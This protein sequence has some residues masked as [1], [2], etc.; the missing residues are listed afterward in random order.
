MADIEKEEE[1]KEEAPDTV[2]A[3]EGYPF[4]R[5]QIVAKDSVTGDYVKR[6]FVIDYTHCC[7]MYWHSRTL[8]GEKCTKVILDNGDAVTFAIGFKAACNLIEP[9]NYF[10][11]L[12]GQYI[13]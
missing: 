10:K 1:K 4:L 3:P 11:M 7:P 13:R 9:F 2:E 8:N 12:T 5:V 6:N